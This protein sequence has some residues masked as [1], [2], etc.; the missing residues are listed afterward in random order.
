M[1]QTH[2]SYWH[3]QP[4]P[5]GHSQAWP[6]HSDRPLPVAVTGR[7]HGPQS[8][9]TGAGLSHR[10]PATV[11]RPPCHRAG[12]QAHRPPGPQAH[13]PTRNTA[14]RP[15]VPQAHRPTAPQPHRPTGPQAHS[16]IA[17][18]PRCQAHTAPQPHRQQASRPRRHRPTCHSHGPEPRLQG[19]SASATG[20]QAHGI[21]V[22]LP[23]WT[24]EV[25]SD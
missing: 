1:R 2:H 9:A 22:E 24:L 12:P 7:S 16:A 18:A 10:P 14:H 20:P 11:P 15:T 8:Q 17:T 3:N 13:R 4:Q 23:C 21:H 19:H 5:A 6:S 25:Q